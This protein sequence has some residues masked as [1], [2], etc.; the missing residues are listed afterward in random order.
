MRAITTQSVLV[1]GLREIAVKV[2]PIQELRA[3]MQR[4]LAG[5][6]SYDAAGVNDDALYFSALPYSRHHGISY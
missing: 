3:M 5:I 4:E 1:G 6:V 2:P